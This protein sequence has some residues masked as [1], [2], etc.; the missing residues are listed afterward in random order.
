MDWY[1]D[2]SDVFAVSALRREIR[3]YLARHGD[4]GSDL[5]AAELVVSELLGNAV[6]H[7]DGPVWVQVV[8]FQ[9]EPTLVVQDLGSSVS[10]E[11]VLGPTGTDVTVR[12][13][14]PDVEGGRGL[15]LVTDLALSHQLATRP[16]GGARAQ[17]RLPV[18]RTV[19]RA[20]DRALDPLP[21]THDALPHLEEAAA[22]G[23]FSRES[24]LRA[25]VVQLAQA[26]EGTHGPDTAEL[27]V[28]HVGATIGSQMENEYRTATAT[29]GPLTPEQVAECLVRLKRAIGGG[30]HIVEVSS[31]RIV[32][33]NTRCPF[34]DAVQRAPALCRMT[35]SVFGGI[36][37]RNSG[38]AAA[39][40]LE[41]RIA[42]GDPGC[43]VVI[44][45]GEQSAAEA[46]PFAHPYRLSAS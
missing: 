45:L 27:L 31:D 23:G 17:A 3:A 13:P 9:A 21:R 14:Q 42:V 7:A 2:G 6:R 8:W 11:A 24:F 29:V 36:A 46:A 43:R 37:A 1:L 44:H 19:Q 15:Y 39:V 12:L 10:L 4:V 18:V 32:L 28:S 34:G 35:S 5:D 22:A 26:V 38:G 40:T 16:G 20:V 33:G 41:E 30:F 25:L